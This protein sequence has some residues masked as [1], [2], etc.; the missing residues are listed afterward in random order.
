MNV[1]KSLI[2]VLV[3]TVICVV[4]G[5]ALAGTNMLT[6]D[7]IAENEAGQSEEAYKAIF[8][9]GGLTVIDIS[10]FELPDSVKEVKKA[11]NGKDYAVM[12][13]TTGY[14]S[15]LVIVVG[16]SSDGKVIGA[17]CAKS[18]ETNKV[19]GTYGDNFK[20]KDMEGVNSVDTISGSTLTTSAYRDAVVTALNTVTVVSGSG[21][22]DFRTDEEKIAQDLDAALPE[23]EGKFTKLFLVEVL[24][25][26]DQVYV[27]DN[28]KGYVIVIDKK[29]VGI[30]ANGVAVNFIDFDT[31]VIEEGTDALKATAEA[32]I[33]VLSASGELI[34]VTLTTEH[35]ITFQSI[36]ER[37]SAI[38]TKLWK[39]ESGNYVVDIKTD[40]FGILGD[41]SGYISGSGEQMEIR[42][43]LT[44]DGKVIDAQTVHH[45]E[46]DSYG[47][48]QLKDGA[49]NSNFIGKTEADAKDVDIVSGCTR[50]TVAYKYAVLLAFQTVTIE[51]G[52]SNE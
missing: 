36:T 14:S 32:A 41:D 10:G 22:A 50:T 18:S 49:Y 29:F 3:L 4:F 11:A 26:V 31:N 46:T 16:V 17:S 35:K 8:P 37:G 43:S 23:A 38:V 39:T 1:K 13:E 6:K 24:E 7:A 42:V 15:G 44:A 5:A 30:D 9:E 52:V 40:G 34:E 48:L 47:G 45:S 12:I 33:P 28:E 25:G 2:D 19:E 21:S 51:G 27:A 20:G